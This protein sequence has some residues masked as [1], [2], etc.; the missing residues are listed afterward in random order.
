LFKYRYHIIIASFALS[1]VLWL[2]LNLN[3]VYEIEKSV[4]IRI[5]V[6]KPYSASGNIPLN[7]DVKFRGV[8]WNLI[9][10]FTSLNL[11]FNYEVNAKKKESFMILTKEYLNNNLGLSQNLSIMSVYPETL[12]VRIEDYEEKYVSVKPRLRVNCMEGY[13]VVGRPIVEPDS[14]KIGGA[15][16]LLKNLHEIST[17]DIVF[18]NVNANIITNVGLSDSL[19]NL[20]KL[21]LNEIN[22]TVNVELTAEKEFHNIEIKIP[23]IPPDK[24]VL[25]IPQS[26][27]VQLKGGVNQLAAVDNSMIKAGID[28]AKILADTSGSLVPSFELPEG[29]TVISFKP[30]TIQYVIKK[31]S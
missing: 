6:N 4:P 20:L 15:V 29:C 28:Y 3:Q 10:L 17:K 19:S 12:F 2:S 27:S 24:E 30:E 13:Q 5:S 14:I 7:L 8:G 16:D 18:S 26:I 9:R 1:G 25:L 31:K 11:E 23:N 22:L 21:S